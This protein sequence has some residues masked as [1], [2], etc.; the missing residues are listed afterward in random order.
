MSSSLGEQYIKACES[1]DCTNS[2]TIFLQNST[3]FLPQISA[4]TTNPKDHKNTLIFDV[5]EQIEIYFHNKLKMLKF[6]SNVF[7]YNKNVR[8]LRDKNLIYKFGE[9]FD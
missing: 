8:F 4:P 9:I 5:E 2:S 1:V 3:A 6:Q 7:N